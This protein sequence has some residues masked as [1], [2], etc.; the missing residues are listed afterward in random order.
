MGESRENRRLFADM[1]RAEKELVAAIDGDTAE[2]D[3]L[4]LDRLKFLASSR[5]IINGQRQPIPGH[6]WQ[7]FVPGKNEPER[8]AQLPKSTPQTLSPLTSGVNSVLRK[9]QACQQKFI[10]GAYA[11]QL[12][13]LLADWVDGVGDS[14]ERYGKYYAMQLALQHN[15]ENRGPM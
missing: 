13:K 1:L 6:T 5:T 9:L 3:K 12:R 4:L 8:V 11:T 14:P 15:L 7:R 10:Q 2:R